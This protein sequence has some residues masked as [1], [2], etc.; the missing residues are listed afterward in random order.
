[1]AACTRSMTQASSTAPGATLPWYPLIE[2]GDGVL[3]RVNYQP[4]L[5]RKC[6]RCPMAS[7]TRG[8]GPPMTCSLV[9]RADLHVPMT[10]GAV[11]I[12]FHVDG[13]DLPYARRRGDVFRAGP[14]RSGTTRRF[15]A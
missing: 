8:D 15:A 11:V 7:S 10:I 4:C 9:R 5:A 14:I 12:A 13:S 1:M 3:A 6:A 2:V